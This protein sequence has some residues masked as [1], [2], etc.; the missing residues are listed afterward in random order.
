M[1]G[2]CKEPGV[3]TILML[4]KTVVNVIY[5]A[6]P[7]TLIITSLITFMKAVC[8]NEDGIKKAQK[9]FV[10]K[11]IS[12]AVIF[13]VPT[14]LMFIM[15]FI[16]TDTSV[17]KTCINSAN[18]EGIKAAYISKAEEYVSIAKETLSQKD[19]NEAK[20]AI[21]R[22]EDEDKKNTLSSELKELE[23]YINLMSNIKNLENNYSYKKY[24]E[25]KDELEK[26]EDVAIKE[27]IETK[28][29]E[30]SETL[31]AFV[32]NYPIVPFGEHELYTNLKTYKGDSLDNLLKKNGSSAEELDE[33][34]KMAV[35]YY[36]VGTRKATVAAAITLIGS[37]A[38]TGYQLPYFWGGKWAKIGVNPNWGTQKHPDACNERYFD[39]QEEIDA[40]IA[41]YQYW[42][43]D[44]SGFVNWAVIQGVQEVRKQDDTNSGKIVLLNSSTA[45]HAVCNI[46]DALETTGHI[47]LVVG[48]DDENKRYIIAEE[49][50]GL[51]IDSIPYSGQFGD[52]YYCVQI[53]DYI[54]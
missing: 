6:A 38:E 54:D 15:N 5:I 9:V 30:V 19:Y 47:V 36:G 28:F 23:G 11:L 40:C 8:S 49:S 43:M 12:A 37:V 24:K 41:R 13:L 26:V 31:F 52:G 18:P 51:E 29:N 16:D 1:F 42:A 35:E 27:K 3:L 21:N 39:T 20:L 32:G 44:C 33:K 22:L 14:I 7:I 34:I 2:I 48:L 53:D 46:G 50:E 4:V 17:L 25:L 45:D 10:N